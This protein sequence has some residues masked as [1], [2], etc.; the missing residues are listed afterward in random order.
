VVCW[1]LNFYGEATVPGG[2]FLDQEGLARAEI[3]GQAVVDALLDVSA[4]NGERMMADAFQG[5]AVSFARY[6]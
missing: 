2:L 1:G 6:C 4:P 3:A 5:F